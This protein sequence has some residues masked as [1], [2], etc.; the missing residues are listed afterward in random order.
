VTNKLPTIFIDADACP[1]TTEALNIARKNGLP[2]VIVG[3]ATQNL[4]KHLK[5]NDST[6]PTT[7]FWV[8]T[9]L[10][11]SGMDSADFAIIELLKEKDIV[12]TQDIGLASMVLGRKA[13]AIGVRGREYLPATIDMDMQIR[14]VEKKVRRQGGRT[15]GPAAFTEDDKERFI[16]T[17]QSIIN[18]ALS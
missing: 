12:V 18:H 16:A 2:V 1:V 13:F 11:S 6:K 3:N 17:M 5:R 8:N 7:G 9:V 10:V 14:H 15:K 4:E